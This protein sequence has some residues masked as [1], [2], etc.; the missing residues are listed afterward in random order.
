MAEISSINPD[1][2]HIANDVAVDA[3][4]YAYVTD[5]LSPVIYRVDLEGNPT[6][7]M[8]DTLFQYLNGI[9]YHPNG[10]LLLG[11]YPGILYK[12]PIDNP[13]VFKVG[14]TDGYWGFMVTDGMIMHPDGTLIMVT[15]PDSEI[16]RLES[17]DDWKTAKAVGISLGHTA[18]YGTT[19]A[20]RGEEVYVIYSHADR[21]FDGLDQS[22]FKIVRVIFE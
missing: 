12:I 20:L 14:I 15:F 2:P 19:V 22:D 13:E 9:V 3:E 1:L 18:G 5:T 7:F 21:Y 6:I 11:S 4:G 10:F 16:G 8:E 17:D